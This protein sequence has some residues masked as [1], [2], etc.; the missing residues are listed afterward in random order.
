M[1]LRLSWLQTWKEVTFVYHKHIVA[2]PS[3]Q[4]TIENGVVV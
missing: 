3:S 1:V 2:K 4:F